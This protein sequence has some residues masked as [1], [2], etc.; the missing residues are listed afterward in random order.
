MWAYDFM[1]NAVLAGIIVATI[2]GVVSVF[3]V[4]R[5]SAFA[6]HALSHM[7]LTGATLGMLLGFSAISGQLFVNLIAALTMGFLGDK[8]KKNDLAIGVVLT[9]VLGL[10]AYFLFLFQNNYSGGV[11]NILFGNI[12]AVS[13]EQIYLLTGLS[14]G[15]LLILT[16]CARPLLFASI[17]PT[18]AEAKNLPI[19][20]LSIVFF[21]IIA[22]TVSMACQI[23]G[24][25]LIFVLLIIPGA[26]AGLWCDGFYKTI[27]VSVLVAN[28]SVFIS[29][30]IAYQFNLPTS[31][32]ITT[33]MSLIY[34]ISHIK[35]QV[36]KL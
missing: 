13:K 26:I 10:G 28:I 8:I 11:L 36:L 2:C 12:L 35:N 25:L 15:I 24:A 21:C 20:F 7:S 16:I 19:R 34:A 33:L 1:Q 4:I 3:V 22:V 31:F 27:L 18:L 29:L 6:A 5:R 23:V 9:F 14:I 32:C 17:D 30:C